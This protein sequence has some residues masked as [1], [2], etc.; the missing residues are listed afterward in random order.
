MKKQLKGVAVG[1]GYF[2]QFHYDAW[3]RIQEVTIG[4]LCD[5]SHEAAETKARKYNIPKIY[6]DYQEMLEKEKPDFIDIITPPDTH[7]EMVKA[8]ANAGV[9]IICQ[10]PLV[11]AFH[12]AKTLIDYVKEKGIRCMVHENFRFQPWYREIKKLLAD[13]EVGNE[14]QHLYF[15]MR[16]GDGWQND[17]YLNRQPYFRE[18]PRLLIYET[19]VHFIDT[20]Q[21]IAGK[22][23]KVYARLRNLNPNI[24]GED[25]GLIFFEFE[26][27]ANG[28]YDASRYH[29]TAYKNPRYTFGEMLLETSRGALKIFQDGTITI[30]PLG[31]PE[32]EHNYFHE[33]R[34]FCGDCVYFTQRHFISSIIN[35]TS[36]E[37]DVASYLQVL[38]V[39]EAIYNSSKKGMPVRLD[40]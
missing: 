34:G 14:I 3:S 28:I 39:Q 10:K 25:S 9:A 31:Q 1:A 12:Q 24:K 23:E 4:A 36:F 17:A 40:K 15:R 29:E 16:M 30:K 26:N 27:K 21:F 11:P 5:Q 2:S 22:I 18:M 6:T 20:F 7:V 38:K 37:T 32:K 8:A 33:D 19:G 35:G 13:G